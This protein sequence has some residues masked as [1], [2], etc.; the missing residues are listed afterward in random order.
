MIEEYLDT[1]TNIKNYVDGLLVVDSDYKIV[2]MTQYKTEFPP[3][4]GRR[5]I[6]KTLFEI[7]PDK[8]PEN[9]TIV[10]AIRYGKPVLNHDEV[11]YPTIGRP[12]HCMDNTYPIR[13]DGKVIGAVCVTIFPENSA[14]RDSLNIFTDKKKKKRKRLYDVSDIIGRSPE[15]QYVRMQVDRIAR[16]SSSVLIYGE[17]G[18]G[19]EM[20]AQSI[21]SASRRSGCPFLSQNCAAIPDNLLESLFFGTARGSYTGAEDRAGLFERAHGGTLFLD[22]INSMDIALQAKLLRVLEDRQV[23]RIG[24]NKSFDVDVRIIAA[25]NKDP[26]ICAKD[27]TLRPDLFYRLSGVTIE[28]PPLRRRTGDIELLTNFFISQFNA[29]MQMEI[30]GVSQ[31]VKTILKNYEWPGNVREF[32]NAIEGAF[33]FCEGRIITVPDLPAYIT[34]EMNL[35]NILPEDS[36]SGGMGLPWMGS[37]KKS[38]DSYEQFLIRKAIDNFSTLSAAAE[39]LGITRQALNQKMKK[40]G[41][42][43]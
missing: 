41:I 9:S 7:Y 4:D 25:T 38:M 43:K 10:Q 36:R 14:N 17:T 18:T 27:G 29:Q 26:A 35:D 23:T 5:A 11:L 8:T 6:G 31:D 19:K 2:Y 24:G 39:Y 34:A 22:E 16:T 15:V 32:R 37:L 20:V 3:V 13:E 28:L 33:N 40:Y 21:H 1:I 12:F 30:S 42:K